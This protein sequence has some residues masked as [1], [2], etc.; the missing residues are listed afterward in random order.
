EAQRHPERHRDLLVR[1]AGYSD[2]F[3]HLTP[4][5]QAEIIARTEHSL[6]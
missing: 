4:E 5:L 2:Y 3:V 1:V 6:V